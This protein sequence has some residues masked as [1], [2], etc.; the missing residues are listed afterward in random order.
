MPKVDPEM[1]IMMLDTGCY[2][3]KD[4]KES[5]EGLLCMGQNGGLF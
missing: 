2:K 3:I 5:I 1:D 4:G